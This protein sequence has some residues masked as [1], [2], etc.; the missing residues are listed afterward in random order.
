MD[1]SPGWGDRPPDFDSMRL[2]SLLLLLS[3]TAA[4]AAAQDPARLQLESYQLPN[5]LSVVLAQDNSAQVV[6]VNVWYDVGSR[7]E[8]PGLT[9]FAHLFEHMMFMGS[10]NVETGQHMALIEG[11]GGVL[12]ASTAEDRTNYFQVVPSNRMNLALWLEADRMRSLDV[13]DANLDIQRNAVQEERRLRVD[14]PPYL[15][16]I[17]EYQYA[18]ADSTSCFPYAHSVIGSMADLNAASLDDVQEFFATYYT[19]NNATLVIAGDFDPAEARALVEQYFGGIERG[20]DPPPTAACN[21]PYSTGQV[22]RTVDDVNATLPAVLQVYRAPPVTSDDYAALELLALIM[23]SGESSRMHRAVVREARAAAAVQV[24]FNALGLRRGP[25][26]FS[27]LSI[28]SG[29]VDADS[30]NTLVASQFASL[31]AEGVT[32]EEL[33]KARNMTRA[34]L[35][36]ERQ[37]AMGRAEAIHR[38]VLF[39]GSPDAINEELARYERV[40]RADI[41][42]VAQTYLVPANSMVFLAV[43]GGAR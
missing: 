11:A 4:S 9:G 39:F 27:V 16:L 6:A 20:P 19:P 24:L 17:F 10:G 12:N 33:A 38:N 36:Q 43:P 5:G 32:A 40:T 18:V 30:L 8:R 21:Q 3:T 42:R 28:A 7:N 37:T 22:T 23:G 34:T 13:T 31:A 29:T 2:A 15:K 26:T 25:G 14:N 41:Q 1:G 35:I